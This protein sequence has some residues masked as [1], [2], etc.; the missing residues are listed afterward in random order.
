[1]M[2]SWL[3]S[4][5]L[6]QEQ[7]VAHCI[8]QGWIS[9]P[10]NYL[11]FLAAADLSPA[12][13]LVCVVCASA[14]FSYL[15][16]DT[17]QLPYGSLVLSHMFAISAANNVHFPTTID[18]GAYVTDVQSSHGWRLMADFQDWF[19]V[20]RDI[21]SCESGKLLGIFLNPRP[22]FLMGTLAQ[23][24]P[25]LPLHFR[26]ESQSVVPSQNHIVDYFWSHSLY[27]T[28]NWI[29]SCR[30]K[31]W[32]MRCEHIFTLNYAVSGLG[33]HETIP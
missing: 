3:F 15:F 31:L 28:L 8:S 7:D 13:A 4:S 9:F 14:K 22:E 5:N 2:P 24:R 23:I 1:M 16:S 25:V 21:F 29:I 11:L 26:D 12:S 30:E 20:Q 27:F 10:L 33:C 6:Q 17:T 18:S 19:K 32:F